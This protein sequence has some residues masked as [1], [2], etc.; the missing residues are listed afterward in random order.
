M[1]NTNLFFLNFNDYEAVNG[2]R[3]S[4][5][6]ERSSSWKFC[7]TGNP[8]RQALLLLT[9][10]IIMPCPWIS[11]R[12]VPSRQIFSKKSFT[13]DIFHARSCSINKLRLVIFLWLLFIGSYSLNHIIIEHTEIN[14][15]LAWLSYL[16]WNYY[17]IMSN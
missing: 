3:T 8:N 7:S 9:G 11:R 15:E 2:I 10:L 12:N 4:P 5:P 13:N 1:S 16:K 17:L 6:Q 14:D